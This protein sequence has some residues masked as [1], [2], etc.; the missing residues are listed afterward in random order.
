MCKMLA[1]LFAFPSLALAEDWGLGL[2]VSWDPVTT[3]ESGE[4]IGADLG[5]YQVGVWASTAVI[6]VAV[7]LKSVD[8]QP[9]MTSV[10]CRDLFAGLGTGMLVKMA[11]RAQNRGGLWSQWS[12]VLG[13][14]LDVTAPAKT[15]ILAAVPGNGQVTLTWT[16][17]V[18]TD[19][20][21][22][23]VYRGTVAGGPY[24]LVGTSTTAT[25]VDLA[26]VNDVV[27]YYVVAAVDLVGN[28]G[29]KS[30]AAACR[31]AA[32]FGPSKPV[33]LK[34]TNPGL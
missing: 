26:V 13:G 22:Y 18:E 12:E 11:V 27:Y 32:A 34:A 20:A 15:Q 6:G 19:L 5:G 29:I 16:V 31:P 1:L 21:G 17:G 30:V 3:Y 14:K 7:P 8:L 24:S 25:L 33:G 4:P 23:R 9:T 28:E 2:T 10:G